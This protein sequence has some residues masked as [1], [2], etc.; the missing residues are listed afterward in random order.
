MQ[1]QKLSCGRTLMKWNLKKPNQTNN[2]REKSEVDF[3]EA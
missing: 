3:A 2:K 1:R